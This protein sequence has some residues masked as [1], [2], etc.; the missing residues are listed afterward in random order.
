MKC[1]EQEVKH[2]KEQREQNAKSI[3]EI[4]ENCIYIFRESFRIC[5][6]F[7]SFYI[8]MMALVDAID[9]VLVIILY[10]YLLD[11]TKKD[12]T[13]QSIM[14]VLILIGGCGGLFTIVVRALLSRYYDVKMLQVSKEIN[15][16]LFQKAVVM[17]ITNFE[18]EAYYD[19]YVRAMENSEV[20]IS[21]TMKAGAGFISMVMS[22]FSLTGILLLV[23]PV[24][25][26]FPLL[27]CA[28]HLISNLSMTR[29]RYNLQRSITPITRKKAYCRRVFYQ[30]EYSKEMRLTDIYEAHSKFYK[31]TTVQELDCERKYASM[32]RLVKMV[33][34]FVG[35]VALVYYFPMKYL[36]YNSVVTERLSISDVAAMNESNQSLT[37]SIDNLANNFVGLQEIGLFGSYYRQFLESRSEIETRTGLLTETDGPKLIEFKNVSFSYEGTSN[38]ALRNINMSIKPGQ[39]IAIVGYN[40]SG[41][42]TLIKLLLNLYSATEGEICYNGKIVEAYDCDSYRSNFGI[43]FQDFQTYALSVRDNILMGNYEGRD[44]TEAMRLANIYNRIDA[45][46][47]KENSILTQEFDENGVL[48]SGGESQRIALARLYMENKSVIILDEH[49]S[50][51]DP[52]T[53]KKVNDTIFNH[54]KEQTIIYISHHLTSVCN[55][56]YIYFLDNGQIVEQGTH[57]DLMQQNHRYKTMFA[58][59]SSYFT[60]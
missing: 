21:A 20:Q 9:S 38:Y 58:K 44:S 53:E 39:K 14:M 31:E 13:F 37:N 32:L 55:A 46:P 29:I 6:L 8:I 57:Q 56:D 41:K 22:V 45:L 49:T 60:A 11:C 33:N 15:V 47:N 36:V 4:G 7:F 28:V 27:A 10:K 48:F 59:Q 18:N 1:E 34:C 52:I 51:M 35:W 2:Q 19:K 42:S 5:K 26:L 40:G 54:F 17:D 24:M 16:K 3:R 23:D 12:V 30:P 50:A 25:F 43:L